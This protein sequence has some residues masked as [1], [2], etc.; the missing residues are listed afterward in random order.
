MSSG[1]AANPPGGAAAAAAD[2][3]GGWSQ[4]RKANKNR[5]VNCE[6]KFE[7]KCPELKKSV[8]DVVT[9]KDTFVKT[10]REIAEY[11]GREFDDAGE[12]RTGMV[13]MALR[14]LEEPAPPTDPNQV[15]EFELWKMARRTYEK[16]AEAR[17]RNSSRVYALILGQCSQALRN[18]MEANEE[19]ERIND[20]SN[21]MDL[22]H[23]IQGCMTQRQ[24]RQKPVHTLMDAEAQVFGFRQK[25]LADN[26][27]YDKFKDLVSIAE[28]L[29]SDIGAQ[30]DRVNTILQSIAAD[31]DI[32]TEL[33]RRQ[34]HEQA[35]D[36]YLAVMFLMNS[37]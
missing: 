18:H 10:T 28:R 13:E 4:R 5:R 25:N 12:F 14:P 22:L 7:G 27:Y 2:D 24:T 29:G 26:E 30:T 36:E 34:A 32:P 3:P 19:W 16:Q 8:Y 20:E 37:D 31:P 6:S 35:K 9:G 17:R 23:L 21:V 15:V 33:E 11:V 1:G